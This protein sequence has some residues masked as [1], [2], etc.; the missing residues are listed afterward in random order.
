MLAIRNDFIE[1]ACQNL[2][3]I[4]HNYQHEKNPI[5]IIQ[6]ISYLCIKEILAWWLDNAMLRYCLVNAYVQIY[7]NFRSTWIQ[8]LFIYNVTIRYLNKCL[9]ILDKTLVQV[10]LN[11]IIVCH[12]PFKDIRPHIVWALT[13]PQ[14][15]RFGGPR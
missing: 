3:V 15:R 12:N 6:I 10:Y 7:L 2:H 5:L 14:G 1:S 11:L 8:P 13:Q 4:N 9:Y